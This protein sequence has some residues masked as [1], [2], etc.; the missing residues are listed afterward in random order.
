M[1]RQG[2]ITL[3]EVLITMVVIAIGMLGMAQLQLGGLRSNHDAYYRSQATGLAADLADR[4][5]ANLPAARDG[6]Y[7]AAQAPDDP[8]YNCQTT[9]PAGDSCTP[10]ELAN[11]DL[12]TWF[13]MVQ[14]SASG[15]PLAQASVAC[16]A[17]CD[18]GD[19]YTITL[20]WDENRNGTIDVDQADALD[21]DPVLNMQ[22]AP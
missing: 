8:G 22:F 1:T 15:L 17:P 9:F 18:I 14:D 21:D 4:M 6:A 19:P 10:T 12:Y 2:G 3:L 11:A 16:A 5:R 20:R 7:E 13:T